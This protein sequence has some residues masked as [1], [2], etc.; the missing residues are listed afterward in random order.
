MKPILKIIFFSVLKFITLQRLLYLFAFLSFGLGD[1]ITGAYI[2]KSTGP[3]IESN[4][5]IRYLFIAHGFE[6]VV[7]VKLSVTF[8]V[9]LLI[10][11]IQG[12]SNVR[13]YW[14]VNMTLIALTSLGLIGIYFNMRALS[15]NPPALSQILF[16]YAVFLLIFIEAGDFLDRRIQ[17]NSI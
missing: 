8:L 1:G 16:M 3:D 5:I 17:E 7:L 10:H 2:M 14:T 12:Q 4:P 13:A 11:R 6:G 9:L 15:V